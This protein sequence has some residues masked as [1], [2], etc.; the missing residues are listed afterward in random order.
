MEKTDNQ[1]H[2]KILRTVPADTV[3]MSVN[4]SKV[5]EE[6]LRFWD[7]V[8]AFATQLRLTEN[9]PRFSFYDG[10]PFGMSNCFKLCH[11][12]RKLM[13]GPLMQSHRYALYCDIVDC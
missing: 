5:E 2:I 11:L 13:S 8:D 4:F 6:T 3:A 12:S 10:P 9:G 1:R 7:E